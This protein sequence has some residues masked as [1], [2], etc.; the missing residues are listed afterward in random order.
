MRDGAGLAILKAKW[1]R[2]YKKY[3][4]WRRRINRP[5]ELC[6]K[7]SKSL[8][9]REGGT[10]AW[11]DEWQFDEGG[12]AR[13]KLHSSLCCAS[14]SSPFP[15]SAALSSLVRSCAPRYSSS[16]YLKK[17]ILFSFGPFSSSVCPAGKFYLS[18][19]TGSR[20]T[21]HCSSLTSVWTKSFFFFFLN[22]HKGM[23]VTARGKEREKKRGFEREGELIS[24]RHGQ[25]QTKGSCSG[26]K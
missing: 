4:V 22:K 23:T 9:Q 26:G 21:Q 16:N 3:C 11:M 14:R 10:G 1:W 15:L 18:D 6:P 24:L 2:K 20:S 25:Q 7:A 13:G 5:G 19:Q 8:K 17:D 12:V